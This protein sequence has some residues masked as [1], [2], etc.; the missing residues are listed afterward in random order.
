MKEMG[1]K[2]QWELKGKKRQWELKWIEYFY[3]FKIST[4]LPIYNYVLIFLT[5]WVILFI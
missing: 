5:Y 2:R 3:F 1:K 4:V